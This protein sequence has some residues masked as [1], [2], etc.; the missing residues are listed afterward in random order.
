METELAGAGGTPNWCGAGAGT[1]TL[2][3]DLAESVVRQ[4]SSKNPELA[5]GAG[6]GRR[7]VK[8]CGVAAGAGAGCGAGAGYGAE[9]GWNHLTTCHNHW[10][11]H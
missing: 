1:W 4:T 9:T 6:E 2:E 5:D 10:R 3:P 7:N 8:E 11:K